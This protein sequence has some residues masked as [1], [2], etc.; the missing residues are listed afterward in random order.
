MFN[1]PALFSNLKEELH[2]SLVFTCH[3]SC[4]VNIIVFC[5]NLFFSSS[6]S[7]CPGVMLPCNFIVNIYLYFYS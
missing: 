6:F 7:Y 5:K 3:Y 4:V 2:T 1:R